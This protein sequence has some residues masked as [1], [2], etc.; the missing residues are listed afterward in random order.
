MMRRTISLY[1]IA[2]HEYTSYGIKKAV[3]AIEAKNFIQ[4]KLDMSSNF[5][6]TTH[7]E[8]LEHLATKYQ[9]KIHQNEQGISLQI[10]ITIISD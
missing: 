10:P 1:R 3:I 2:L 9:S 7:N 8:R 5:T 4:V 6:E